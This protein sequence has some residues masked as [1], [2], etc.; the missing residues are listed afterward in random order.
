MVAPNL[1]PTTSLTEGPVFAPP[2][3]APV[4]P[5]GYGGSSGSGGPPAPSNYGGSSGSGGPPAPSGYGGSGGPPA[6]YGYSGS[7]RPPA[8]SGS[9]GSGRP[10]APSDLGGSGRPQAPS[11]ASGASGVG[12]YSPQ[13]FDYIQTQLISKL[14]NLNELYLQSIK[15]PIFGYINTPDMLKEITGTANLTLFGNSREVNILTSGNRNYTSVNIA[16]IQQNL[17]NVLEISCINLITDNNTIN[18]IN[19]LYTL[20]AVLNS[21]YFEAFVENTNNNIELPSLTNVPIYSGNSITKTTLT[22]TQISDYLNNINSTLINDITSTPHFNA[23]VARRMVYLWIL[24]YN[25]NIA[26][27]LY[28]TYPNDMN[29][30][31]A[32]SCLK[33]I[34]NNNDQFDYNTLLKDSVELSSSAQIENLQYQVWSIVVQ[35][36]VPPQLAIFTKSN[37]NIDTIIKTDTCTSINPN[38]IN[39]QKLFDSLLPFY[40]LV[41]DSMVKSYIDNMELKLNSITKLPDKCVNSIDRNLSDII[42][43]NKADLESRL[44]TLN[45]TTL[46]NAKIVKEN[47][48]SAYTTAS[49]NLQASDTAVFAAKGALDTAYSNV[50]AAQSSLKLKMDTDSSSL[51]N[52]YDYLETYRGLLKTDYDAL[53]RH[54]TSTLAEYDKARA[55]YDQSQRDLASS[56][57]AYEQSQGAL[58]SSQA[59]LESSQSDYQKSQQANSSLRTE[60]TNL[61]SRL[62]SL[63]APPSVATFDNYNPIQPKTEFSVSY[64]PKPTASDIAS[65]AS[66]L[67]QKDTAYTSA[68]GALTNAL[69]DYKLKYDA[70]SKASTEQARARQEYTDLGVKEAEF[71]LILINATSIL[72]NFDNYIPTKILLSDIQGLTTEY[73]KATQAY[74]NKL[75]LPVPATNSLVANDDLGPIKKE[76]SN[77]VKIYRNRQQNI[78]EL[79]PVVE[80]NKKTLKGNRLQLQAREKNAETLKIYKYIALTILILITIFAFTIII[81]PLD[82]FTKIILTILLIFISVCNTYVLMYFFDNNRL[83]ETFA[84]FE[85]FVMNTKA[86]NSGISTAPLGCLDAAYN[87]LVQTENNN[88][89]LESNSIYSNTNHS[90]NKEIAYYDNVSKQ[91]DYSSQKVNSIYKSSFIAQIQYKSTIQL[92]IT[93]TIIIAAYTLAYV[94]LESLEITGSSYTVITWITGIFLVISIIIYLIEINTRVRTDP[95]KIYWGKTTKKID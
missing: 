82:K 72:N 48:E 83:F 85:T 47:A 7:G 93:F 91:L 57:R 81:M 41:D 56:Q 75:T 61:Q 39:V 68:S 2:A 21:N 30:V 95:K 27:K 44:R 8:P 49:N 73:F 87:Y 78:N 36:L 51:N 59:S 38:V 53:Y 3:P 46:P 84:P 18:Y 79:G 62:N 22:A 45:N 28:T 35:T 58:A 74:K 40:N 65:L 80:H 1:A 12:G 55:S 33:V 14:K 13:D 29:A 54:D 26:Y 25:F 10:P 71:K 77:N 64:A 16:N 34:Q 32:L 70:Y 24:M 42:D 9:S 63:T 92:F 5:S 86:Y 37:G 15:Q 60:I 19:G 67:R 89:L 94:F 17:T 52:A 11:G 76:T 20:Y 6:P 69:S 90:L 66:T 31:L 23:F 4:S 43:T 88:I 50:T